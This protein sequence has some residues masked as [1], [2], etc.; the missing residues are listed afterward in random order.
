MS[1]QPVF[2]DLTSTYNDLVHKKITVNADH[3]DYIY[4][5]ATNNTQVVVSGL[6]YDLQVKESP[7]EIKEKIKSASHHI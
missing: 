5:D 6:R 4:T 7:D 3:I 1:K 2:I